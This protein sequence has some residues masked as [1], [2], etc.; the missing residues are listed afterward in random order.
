MHCQ[1]GICIDARGDRR[2]EYGLANRRQWTKDLSA[3]TEWVMRYGGIRRQS[4]LMF[5]VED[6]CRPLV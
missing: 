3:V 6:I 2:K 5:Q 1:S 4:E